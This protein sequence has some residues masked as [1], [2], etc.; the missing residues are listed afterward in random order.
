MDFQTANPLF[1][2][3]NNPWDLTRTP[4]GSTGGG[5]AAVAAGLTPLDF[6]GDLGGS[7][8]IPAAFCGI[9][10]HTPS[11]TAVPRRGHFPGP[12]TPNPVKALIVLGPLARSAEDLE[13]AFDVIAGP[14]IGED[15]AW[16]LEIP[17]ARHECLA[18]YR[19]AVIPPI[20]WLQTDAEIMEALDRLAT[21]LG[22]VG[23]CVK[24]ACPSILGDIREYYRIYHYLGAVLV[25][26]ET[27]RAERDR[28]A[29]AIRN[30]TA[31]PWSLAY[32]DGLQGDAADY[33]AWFAQCE[34]YRAG[35]REFFD[36][37]DIL[38]SPANIVNAFPHTDVPPSERR[39]DV[40][41]ESVWYGLQNVYASLS[42]LSGHPATVFPVGQTRSGL[43]IGL[44][45]LGPYLE[46]RTSI[47]FAA[48]VGQETGGFQA[49]PGYE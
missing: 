42:N 38:L 40:N 39:L 6:G 12:N 18:D 17:P 1:G 13:L 49:P 26:K 9:Y 5:S 22:R 16:R 29:E 25:S 43:P 35:L 36:E 48:L 37:W 44:Q 23:A 32:A 21:Q 14:D 46:D 31:N 47:R 11:G 28:Q 34:Q 15:A 33:I 3:T 19:V 10:G 20:E 8:R 24:E 30:R 41:G 45:A 2:R 4:G 7:V 27:P